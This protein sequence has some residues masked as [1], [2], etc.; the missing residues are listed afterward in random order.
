MADP[1]QSSQNEPPPPGGK[2]RRLA[3]RYPCPQASA[4]TILPPRHERAGAK[5]R[6]LSLHGIGLIM[7]RQFKPKTVMTL[8]L[9]SRKLAARVEI[10][11]RV[12]H[13]QPSPDGTWSVG[14]EFRTPFTPEELQ[15]VLE[16]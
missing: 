1:N 5:I 8:E 9:R 3:V 12:I 4:T 16:T 2:E 11:V 14:C 13:C 15:T 7:N 6:D 10:Q